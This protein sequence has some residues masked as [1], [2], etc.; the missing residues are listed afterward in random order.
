[1]ASAIRV[2]FPVL[3]V[4]FAPLPASQATY[5]GPCGIPPPPKPK[6]IKGGEGVPPLPLP[7]TPLRR[8]ERKR[9][10][11][12][13]ILIGKIV[14]G[15]KRVLTL[16]DGRKIPYEDW[17]L[18][19]NDVHRLLRE[20]RRRLGVRYRAVPVRLD[21]FSFDPL[22]IP[23][24]Y[25]T[26][27]RALSFAPEIRKKLRSYCL[28]GGF[29][30]LDACRGSRVFAG[31]A[32][33]ELR[34]IFPER[35]LHLLP[36]DHP[37]FSAYRRVERVRYSP[38]V[39]ER[40]EGAPVL[41]GIDLGCRTM[42]VLSPY[43]LSCAWDSDHLVPGSRC[44]LGRDAHDL[45]LNL[46]SYALGTFDLGQFYAHGGLKEPVILMR[47]GEGAASA[48][49]STASG[50]EF[51]FAQLLHGEGSDPDPTAFARLLETVMAN[52]SISLRLRRKLLAPEDPALFSYPFL[53]MTGHYD[54]RFSEK[55]V[56][57]LRRH[58]E[59]GGFLFADSCCGNLTFDSA[60]R[61]E[62][63]RI[64]PGLKLK[65]VPP[66]HPVYHAFY[67]VE[68][69]DLTPKARV[70]FPSLTAPYLEGIEIDGALR[71]LY[72]PLD[73]GNGWEG[74][75]HAY[76]RGYSEACALKLGVNAI[77]YALSH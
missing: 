73:L 12:P 33:S 50:G 46:I 15:E 13:P 75:P 56:R 2:L 37:I 58:L 65:P 1:M 45:G 35:R 47:G 63:K 31:A 3:A 48:S 26:G 22:E 51:V 67:S 11:Q 42:V 23:I 74:V 72:S 17:N 4:L 61:R 55:A 57:R 16:R 69:A 30:L 20:A 68:K 76:A 71:V 53:Y 8:T 10:P 7:A 21:R 34:A 28:R 27:V 77:A 39:T 41:E 66:D 44:V 49:A 60:F 25:A 59:A 36:P 70:T 40:P 52:T 19:P 64:L 38:A 24:L 6:R 32:R 43:G 5:D 54:F 62:I 14:W 29:F 18:D 9:D